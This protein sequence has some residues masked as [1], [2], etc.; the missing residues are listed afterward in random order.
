MLANFGSICLC[1]GSQLTAKTVCNFST[2]QQKMLN[3][4]MQNVE[5]N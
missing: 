1:Q 3:M 5:D 4:F 2:E